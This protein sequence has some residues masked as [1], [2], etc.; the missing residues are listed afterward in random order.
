[1]NINIAFSLSS[2]QFSF[3]FYT[4]TWA[5]RINVLKGTAPY[6]PAPMTQTGHSKQSKG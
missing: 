5:H 3:F 6:I 1:M 4:I 2:V